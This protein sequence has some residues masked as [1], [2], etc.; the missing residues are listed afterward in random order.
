MLQKMIRFIRDSQLATPDTVCLERLRLVTEAYQQ[1]AG[2]PPPS[3]RA[4][5]FAYVLSQ[6]T[7]DL[8]SNPIFA[9]NTSSAPR[10]WML[11]PEY[12]FSEPFQIV[13]E[14]DHL[15]GILDGVIPQ[16]L[17]DFWKPL[18]FGGNAGIGHL[19][20]D[21]DRVVHEGLAAILH[22]CKSAQ[23]TGTV[24]EQ[25]Y[26]QAMAIT[27]QAVVDWAHRYAVAADNAAR[28]AGDSLVRKCHQRVADACRRVPALP[29]R[30]LFEAL[31]AIVLVHLAIHIEGQGLSVSIGL[32]DRIL[33]PYID[34]GFDPEVAADLLS[35]FVLKINANAL[36]GSG[37]KTQP[38]TIGGLD[39]LGNDQCNDMTLCILDAVDR[40]RVGDPHLFLRW[41]QKINPQVKARAVEMLAAGVSMPLLIH[42]IPTVH[43]FIEAGI[44]PEDAWGYCVIGCNELGIPG[45]LWESATSINGNIVYLDLLNNVLLEYPDLESITSTEALL[46]LLERVMYEA[47]VQMRE[48]GQNYKKTLAA[49]MPS[50]FTSALMPNCVRRGMDIM[51]GMEYHLP[52][53]YER[54]FTNAVNALAV[55]DDLVFTR[56]SIT[57]PDLVN[58]MHRNYQGE[59][60][61]LAQIRSAPKWGTDVPR[62]DRW[63]AELIALRERVLDSVDAQS[64]SGPHMVCHVIRSLH[65]TTGKR[66]GASPDGRLAGTPVAD[67]LGAETGTAT[68]GPTGV[69]NSV[70]KLDAAHYYRGGTNLDLTLPTTRWSVVEMRNN[71]LAMIETF[72]AQ[73][74]QELQ[75]ACLNAA[76]LRDALVN[77]E[78]H[79]DLLVRVAGFNA[80]FVDLSKQEQEEILNRAEVATGL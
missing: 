12:G 13:I 25:Q 35:A 74:G 62:A 24:E 37:S 49:K 77:P 6:M 40:V 76:E 10:A 39:A 78:N 1:Y 57:L 68:R 7:L 21:Y 27:L 67:S 50:P 3:K 41:H 70:V 19:A 4:K 73:G 32:L 51:V 52:G 66:I 23:F 5:A 14:H 20:V 63:A 56:H 29:A 46:P 28:T 71:L 30:T 59:E 36:F 64:G 38:I 61:L 54:S 45:K 22:E 18:S 15:K 16:D 53:I 69:L 60:A 2:E 72:F 55:I 65:Y 48:N 80:R 44:P 47:A 33:A 31:Q 79:G 9:G 58:A 8:D 26:R 42:D 34:D 17:V 75:V 11:V 43:G